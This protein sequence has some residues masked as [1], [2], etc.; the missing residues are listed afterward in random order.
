MTKKRREWQS[1]CQSSAWQRRIS[2]HEILAVPSESMATTNVET[3]EHA[4]EKSAGLNTFIHR[5]AQQFCH[6]RKLVYLL[7]SCDPSK[8]QSSHIDASHSRQPLVKGER[9]VRYEVNAVML[10]AAAC[11][12]PLRAKCERLCFQINVLKIIAVS[13]KAL[14]VTRSLT[15]ISVVCW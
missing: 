7:G 4:F 11:T 12:S 1:V 9:L 5:I 13:V 14:R 10:L 8:I 3:Q 2:E 6:R 15:E